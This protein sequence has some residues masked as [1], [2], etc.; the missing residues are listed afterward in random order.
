MPA[1]KAARPK[2][3]VAKAAPR[4][5]HAPRKTAKTA[6]RKAKIT[7]RSTQGRKAH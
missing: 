2:K 4:K 7:A 1:K 5:A 3:P 6:A